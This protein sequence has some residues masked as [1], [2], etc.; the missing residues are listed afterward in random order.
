MWYMYISPGGSE[1]IKKAIGSST[2]YE[3]RNKAKQIRVHNS[4]AIF[5]DM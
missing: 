2:S 5:Y 3:P 4:L 1:V